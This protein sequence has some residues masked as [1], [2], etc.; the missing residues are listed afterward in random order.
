MSV[1]AFFF[2]GQQTHTS[3]LCFILHIHTYTHIK[4][5]TALLSSTSAPCERQDQGL[6][7]IIHEILLCFLLCKGAQ[8][9]KRSKEKKKRNAQ[10]EEEEEKETENASQLFGGGQMNERGGGRALGLCLVPWVLLL[11]KYLCQ[12]SK[13][14][15][16]KRRMQCAWWWGR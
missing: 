2:F 3:S 15:R 13:R 4:K 1:A 12:G 14:R 11:W 7:F 5:S 8:N 16:K 9:K 6:L 10:G